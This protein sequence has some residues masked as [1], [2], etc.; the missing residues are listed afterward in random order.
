MHQTVNRVHTVDF[1]FKQDG[2]CLSR[3][4]TVCTLFTVW[5]SDKSKIFL[6]MLLF[7]PVAEKLLFRIALLP[8]NVARIDL[9]NIMKGYVLI[10]LIKDER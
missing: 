2:T 9:S 10:Y 5:C 6:Q 1:Q 3:K 8:N 7:F 4:T